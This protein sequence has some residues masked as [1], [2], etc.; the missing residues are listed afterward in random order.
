M[1]KGRF[2]LVL[3]VLLPLLA[4]PAHAQ[5]DDAPKIGV[6]GYPDIS[7]SRDVAMIYYNLT[8][9]YP[10]FRRWLLISPEYKK[11]TNAERLAAGKTIPDEMA[12]KFANMQPGTPVIVQFMAVLGA[13]DAEKG[14][15][16]VLN[17]DESVF[18]PYTHDGKH[19]AVIPQGLVDNKFLP[20]TDHPQEEVEHVL[21][22]NARKIR[23][24][25]YV[26][27]QKADDKP[28]EMPGPDGHPRAYLPILGKV[29]NVALY[30][31]PKKT[32][33]K[34][35]WEQGSAEYRS[36]QMNELLNLKQ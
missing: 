9:K 5:E 8:G 24:I 31:C 6:Q 4:A 16:K 28:M 36:K 25:V 30:S 33:C 34:N 26:K 21:K 18:F 1:K 2:W 20:V 22:G 17:I 14:G 3:A 27:P 15:Y 35:L 11:M 23:L 19:Y 29:A 13:Y 10:D 12:G 7:N 32:G